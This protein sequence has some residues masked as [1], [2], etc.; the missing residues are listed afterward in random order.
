MPEVSRWMPIFW[1]DYLRDTAH[2]TTAENGAYLLLIG[3]YWTTGEALPD[4]DERLRRITRMEKA[5]WK[6]ARQ[7]VRSFFNPVDGRLRHKRID[8]ELERAASKSAARKKSGANGAAAKWGEGPSSDKLKRS[9]RLAE[10]R[11]LGTHTAEEWAAL[12]ECCDGACVR[13]SAAGEVVK[14]HIKPIYQGGSDA[15]GNLQPLCRTCNSSKGPEAVD[16][17]RSDW[18]KCVAERL[19][20]AWQNASRTPAPSPSQDSVGLD[21]ESHN[22]QPPDETDAP[23][24]ATTSGK[25]SSYAFV[26]RVIKLNAKDYQAWLKAYPHLPLDAELTSRDAW[27]SSEKADED[28]RKSWFHSTAAQ[29]AKLERL[30]KQQADTTEKGRPL[31]YRLD[32]KTAGVPG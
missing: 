17:R 22:N 29:L 24:G 25:R 8:A 11:K 20:N 7:T 2:L 16:Y 3:H 27:L 26:G 30:A 19:A 23:A 15:I 14:D 12:V 9:E 6:K 5:E 13:C 1:G 4:D 10:A 18:A 32:P 31:D 28:D 21:S